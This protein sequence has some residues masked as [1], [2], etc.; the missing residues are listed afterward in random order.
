LLALGG[1]EYYWRQAGYAPTLNDTSDLWAAART[2]LKNS[3]P[4]RTVIIGSSR[5]LFDFDIDVYARY[6]E[7]DK[8]VQLSVAG[9]T[10]LLILEHLADDETFAGT[11]LCG[12]VPGLFFAPEG[13]PVE[14][15]KDSIKRYEQWAP[16][17][18]SGHWLG[19]QL[20]KHLAFLQQEDLTL[21]ALLASISIPNRPNTQIRPEF[22]PY[23][24]CVTEDRRIRLWVGATFD[25]PRARR[26]QQIWL[27][28]F[29]PPPPP[30][31]MAPETFRERFMASVDSYLERTHDAV[32]KIRS[33]GGQV[34]FIRCP[35]SGKLRELEAQLNPRPVFWER[36]LA[37][38][39]APG[40]HFEDH[41]TLEHFRCPEWSHLISEDATR[42]TENLMPILATVL[43]DAGANSDKVM[44]IE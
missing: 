13:P 18:R 16:S 14:R 17:Q 4:E 34:V 32:H 20:E 25:T 33:R 3:Q 30:P 11:V 42:F 43:A 27:P 8:P 22:P 9:T 1:W 38:T 6:F 41:P 36:I 39:G 7:T 2:E 28:L 15:S 12:I 19:I 40:I 10:P 5:M 35:S 24:G 31:G 23:F 44:S 26:I 37:R 21:N 29:T